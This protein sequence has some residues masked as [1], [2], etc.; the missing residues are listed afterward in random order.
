MMLFGLISMTQMTLTATV[1]QLM[2]PDRLRGRMMGFFMLMWGFMPLGALL[3]GQAAEAFGVQVA[4][5]A[6]SALSLVFVIGVGA[7]MANSIS[8][9]D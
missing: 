8:K 9:I 5:A 3:I 6:A 7:R 1:M 4:V 2:V